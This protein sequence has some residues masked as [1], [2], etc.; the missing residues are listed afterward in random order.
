[1][2]EMIFSSVLNWRADLDPDRVALFDWKKKEEYSWSDLKL[3]SCSL[4]NYLTEKINLKKGDRIGFIVDTDISLFDAF[5]ASC[6]TGAI[7]TT[8]NTKFIVSETLSMIK[9]ESPRLIFFSIAYEDK[10]RQIKDALDYQCWFVCVDSHSQVS[11]I[12]YDDILSFDPFHAQYTAMDDSDPAMLI[13][14]GGTTGKPKA[15]IISHKALFICALNTVIAWQVS[16]DDASYICMP[17][18]HVGGWNCPALGMLLVGAKIIIAPAFSPETMLQ[19]TQAERPS[20]FLATEA[21]LK[22]ISAHKDF[23]NTDLSCYRWIMAGGS[24]IT[25]ATMKPFWARGIKVLNGYG[26]TEIVSF[27]LTSSVNMPLEENKRKIDSVGKPLPLSKVMIINENGEK[28]EQG[29]L[30]EIIVKGEGIFSGYWGETS[31]NTVV[32]ENGWVHTGDLGF[33]DPDGDFYV[34]GRKKDMF[35]SGG[36][37]IF[38]IEVENV[39]ADHPAITECAVIGV[40]DEKW[41]EVGCA[42]L[43]IDP[44]TSL[45]TEEMDAYLNDRISTIKKPRHY[46]F[47]DAIPKTAVGKKDIAALRKL[48]ESIDLG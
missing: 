24:P 36:E 17:F 20:F 13:H 30:G 27:V 26:M 8:Y 5:F 34:R 14:T 9:S 44:S 15:A 46:A 45:S 32:L 10:I 29:E 4:A 3:R 1:M 38:P 6:I 40:P 7:I 18:F 37:N 31:E 43:T 2:N 28:A 21:M 41:G 22:T 12:S 39:L 25:E 42:F 23:A 11:D 35:I 33:V 48:A 19:I 47:V 16:R